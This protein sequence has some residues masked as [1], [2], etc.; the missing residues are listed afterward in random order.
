[1]HVVN[2]NTTRARTKV[3]FTVGEVVTVTVNGVAKT[4]EKGT[5]FAEPKAP[6]EIPDGMKFD[7]WYNGETKFD[8]TQPVN[9]DV[10]LTAKFV[11]IP[12]EI[13]F[14][15]TEDGKIQASING[16][17]WVDVIDKEE[18]KGDKGD[19]GADGAPGEKGDKGD[20]GAPGKDGVD[21]KDAE[22][23]CGSSIGVGGAVTLM[24]ALAAIGGF[25]IVR[26]A[27]KK[28]D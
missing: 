22:G 16:G 7:G 11:P 26:R 17:E 25:V 15:V 5:T 4:I 28:Q 6:T 18:I 3:T 9:E 1:M 2:N 20:T 14:R 12:D 24:A 21:G 27:S 19:T 23:G 8:F 10:T 13:E